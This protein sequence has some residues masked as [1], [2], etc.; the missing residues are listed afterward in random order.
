[1][2]FLLTL[3]CALPLLFANHVRAESGIV[4]EETN[5]HALSEKMQ[6][7]KMGLVL[8]LHA[9]HCHYC[10]MMDKKILS[11]M[12]RSGEYNEKVFIRKLQV[13]IEDEIVGFKGTKTTASK[14][15]S[16]YDATFTPTL[17]FLDAKGTEQVVK[18]IGLNSL[19]FFGAAVEEQIE[20][21]LAIIRA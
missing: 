19:E 5:F 8:L 12:I 1:M 13:G 3:L 11:P 18:I 14:L 4:I 17:L 7:K 16:Q 9:E 10:I 2:K 20:E 21:L 6:R 15:I